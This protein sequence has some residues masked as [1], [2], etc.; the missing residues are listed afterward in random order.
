MFSGPVSGLENP[1]EM[2][3]LIASSEADGILV[4]PWAL[5]RLAPALGQLGAVARLDGGNTCLGQRIDQT[6]VVTSVEQ[7]LRVGADMVALNIFVGGENE[8][9]MLQK[10]G[11]ASEACATW[12]VPLMAE[13]IPAPAL[14]HHYGKDKK[15][16][17]DYTGLDES[18]AIVS[19]IGAE[20]GAD[21]IKT[22]YPGKPDDLARAVCTATVPIVIAGGPK[23]G[24]DVEFLSMVKDCVAAG[25]AGVCMGRNVWQRPQPERMIA[26]LCAIVHSDASVD[27]AMGLL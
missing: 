10:L 5:S 1:L 9:E 12:G 15:R 27:E 21:I 18:V 11:R 24:S 20:F 16:P 13:M 14:T 25:A 26:A 22:V 8:A 2:V 6:D 17:Y 7:A 19:R 23:T 4:S 3:R